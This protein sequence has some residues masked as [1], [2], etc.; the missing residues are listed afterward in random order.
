VRIKAL[1]LYSREFPTEYSYHNFLFIVSFENNT[2][3]FTYAN[4][5]FGVVIPLSA[6]DNLNVLPN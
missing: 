1:K 2:D 5:N 3:I 4:L 6:I